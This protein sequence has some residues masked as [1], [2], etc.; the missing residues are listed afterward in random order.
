M[1]VRLA[2]DADL[3]RLTRLVAEVARSEVAPAFAP[4]GRRLLEAALTQEAHDARRR[5]GVV[6]HLAESRIGGDL[7]GVVAMR[8]QGHLLLLFV[9]PEAQGRGVARAL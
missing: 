4:E 8:P 9:D 7:L 2:E 5:D 3:A 6:Y 1:I